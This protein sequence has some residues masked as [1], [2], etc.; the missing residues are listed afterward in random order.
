[1]RVINNKFMTGMRCSVVWCG[2]TFDSGLAK[3]F[4]GMVD[5]LFG[6][7]LC[8]YMRLVFLGLILESLCL[9]VCVLGFIISRVFHVTRESRC[10]SACVG[11][12]V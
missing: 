7:C 10:V 3:L 9:R 6:F 5:L 8:W 1:M 12:D 4:D 11:D 2:A